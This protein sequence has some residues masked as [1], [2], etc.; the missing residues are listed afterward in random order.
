MLRARM[1]NEYCRTHYSLEEVAEMDDLLF[2][3]LGAV[4]RGMEP[5]KKK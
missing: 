5:P 3:V 2:E 4:R 1:L